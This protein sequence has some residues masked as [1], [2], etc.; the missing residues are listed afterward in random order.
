M[1][2]IVL[3]ASIKATTRKWLKTEVP[4][5]KDRV[6][7]K[8]DMMEKLSFSFGLELDKSILKCSL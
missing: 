3:I 7:V 4:K 6:D 8:H 2:R 1:C 5:V